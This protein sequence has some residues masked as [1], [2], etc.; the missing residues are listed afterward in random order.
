MDSCK[1]ER[2]KSRRVT[3]R[4]A[5]SAFDVLV[6]DC[7]MSEKPLA[8]SLIQVLL[9]VFLSTYVLLLFLWCQDTCRSRSDKSY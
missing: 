6:Q 4:M 1:S 8:F 3:E 5:E 9:I 7:E 2:D